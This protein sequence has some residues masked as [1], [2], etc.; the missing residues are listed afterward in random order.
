MNSIPPNNYIT[1]THYIHDRFELYHRP[2]NHIYILATQ[3]LFTYTT[4]S[5]SG[6]SVSE[7]VFLN[8][9]RPKLDGLFSYKCI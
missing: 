8:V 3:R 9:E 7:N 1:R 5:G 6:S 4:M 2:K